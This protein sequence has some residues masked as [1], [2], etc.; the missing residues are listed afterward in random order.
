MSTPVVRMA[1]GAVLARMASSRTA[2]VV[3]EP[4]VKGRQR[5]RPAAIWPA[6]GWR[7][8]MIPRAVMIPTPERERP[9]AYECDAFGVTRHDH[10]TSN[11][12]S[13]HPIGRDPLPPH[14]GELC[15]LPCNSWERWVSPRHWGAGEDSSDV[16]F[17]SRA[18]CVQVGTGRPP[19]AERW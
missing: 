1:A 16:R 17:P 2:V 13:Q 10:P 14:A 15:R 9:A 3:E 19:S 8:S 7:R 5:M 12:G 11:C 6:K 18:S 4:R